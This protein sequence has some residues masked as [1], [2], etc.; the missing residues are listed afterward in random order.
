MNDPNQTVDESGRDHDPPVL[1]NAT[2]SPQRI[3]RYR[4][5]KI[6]GE[7]GFGMIYLAHDDQLRRQMGIKVSH[8]RQQRCGA[9]L[10]ELMP[11]AF[12][13][14]DSTPPTQEVAP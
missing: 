7:R 6:L 13:D 4:V 12:C 2:P 8:R 9:M 1:T 11:P 14:G 10:I 5:E 3:G